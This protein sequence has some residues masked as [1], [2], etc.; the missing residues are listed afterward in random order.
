MKNI[1][2]L[3]ALL[4]MI[5]VSCTQKQSAEIYTSS[6]QAIHGYDPVSYF[7]AANPMKGSEEFSY[8]W[9]DAKWL[10]SSQQ[11]LDSFAAN[12]EKY[13]PQYGGWCAFGCSNE[14]KA[15]TDPNA[16]TIVDGKLYL[17]HNAEVRE[18]WL[19]EQKQRIELADKNWLVIKNK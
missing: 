1:Y 16:W 4:V 7:T 11:N 10:F 2:P 8:E 6:S 14:R 5:V 19:K 18:K 13:A 17:N 15:T 12:P 9:K 3:M